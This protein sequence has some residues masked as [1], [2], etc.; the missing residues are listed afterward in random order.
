MDELSEI[1]DRARG[2]TDR[3]A[4]IRDYADAMELV[5]QLAVEMP[6]YQRKDL[7]VFNSSKIDRA[8]LTPDSEL[9]PNNGLFA[10]IWEMDFVK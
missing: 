3:N 1:I 4:R 2:T 7:T 9:G 8:T 5:M 6:T 10:R